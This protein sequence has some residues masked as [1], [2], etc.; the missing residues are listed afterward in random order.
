MNDAKVNMMSIIKYKFAL[1]HI[2]VQVDRSDPRLLNLIVVDKGRYNEIS[3]AFD[4]VKLTLNVKKN[5]E[6]QRKSA[7]NTEYLLLDSYF[8]DLITKW[9]F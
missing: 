9:R 2:E 6:E 4:D 3:L 1:R 7:R 8:D 5:L